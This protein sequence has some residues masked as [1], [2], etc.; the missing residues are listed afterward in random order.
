MGKN[1]IL[2]GDLNVSR[3]LI[4]TARAQDNM[5]AEGMTHEEYLST[6]NR[7]IFNQLLLTN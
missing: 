2:T 5:L 7:R 4:D 1:V 6:P 3:D